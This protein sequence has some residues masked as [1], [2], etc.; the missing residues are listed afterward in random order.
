[1]VKNLP[2]SAGGL[3][4]IPG[5]ELRSHMPQATK[6]HSEDSAQPKYKRKKYGF[7]FFEVM[8]IKVDYGDS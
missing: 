2:S 5:R 1:M 8:K 4:S 7:G 6:H 3:G